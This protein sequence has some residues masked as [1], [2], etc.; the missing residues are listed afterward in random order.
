MIEMSFKF[1]L[2][3]IGIE[4]KTMIKIGFRLYHIELEEGS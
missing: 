3:E 4:Y 2:A 1:W